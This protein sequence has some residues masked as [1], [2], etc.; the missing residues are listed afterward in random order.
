MEG[1]SDELRLESLQSVAAPAFSANFA[2][3]VFSE[4]IKCSARSARSAT[5]TALPPVLSAQVAVCCGV[6]QRVAA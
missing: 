6:L 3:S 2:Q 4:T 5:R 1:L